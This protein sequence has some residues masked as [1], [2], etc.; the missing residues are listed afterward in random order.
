ML[1]RRKSCAGKRPPRCRTQNLSRPWVS[2]FD[3]RAGASMLSSGCGETVKHF[4]AAPRARAARNRR[5]AATGV[6]GGCG[7]RHASI[8][9]CSNRHRACFARV[10]Q[11]YLCR[12]DAKGTLWRCRVQ[13]HDRGGASWRWVAPPQ[14][15]GVLRQNAQKSWRWP[16]R[17]SSTAAALDV[18]KSRGSVENDPA[19]CPTLPTS[20]AQ[21]ASAGL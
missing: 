9:C 19:N 21:I 12:T 3:G 2:T 18:T 6:R 11:T 5:F 20:S 14:R 4:F 16:P 17:R 1:W 13:R 10:T 7:H 8:F 15:G